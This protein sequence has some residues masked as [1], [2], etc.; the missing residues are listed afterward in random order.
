MCSFL[1]L[2]GKYLCL[3][4]FLSYCSLCKQTGV[5]GN[6]E[7]WSR[8]ARTK[9]SHPLRAPPP[10]P[11]R[12]RPFSLPCREPFSI[13]TPLPDWPAATP[14]NPHTLVDHQRPRRSRA[15]AITPDLV[16]PHLNVERLS[17]PRNPGS[18][19]SRSSPHPLQFEEH[20]SHGERAVPDP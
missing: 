15:P 2:V 3:G 12:R 4:A 17:R 20:R 1:S 16:R 5:I 6:L 8:S 10:P 11:P 13:R 18:T 7:S 19:L 9:P 14:R